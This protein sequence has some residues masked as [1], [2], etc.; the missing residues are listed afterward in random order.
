MKCEKREANG[1]ITIYL[2]LTMLIMMSLLLTLLEGIRMKT[3]EFQAKCV[4]DIGIDSI[5]AEYHREVLSRYGL[6]LVDTSYGTSCGDTEYTKDHLLKYMNM[7]FVPEGRNNILNYRDLTALH[8]DNADILSIT[9]ATD[10]EA[11]VLRYQIIRYMKECGGLSYA[12]ALFSLKDNQ[13]L[14]VEKARQD[15]QQY[16]A[17]LNQ[18]MKEL[19]TNP[20]TGVNPYEGLLTAMMNHSVLDYA[21]KDPSVLSPKSIDSDLY[22]SHRD[23]QEGDGLWEEQES[24]S[25]MINQELCAS[26]Y[27]DMCGNYMDIKEDTTLDYEV[28]YLLQGKDTDKKNLEKVADDIF[29]MRYAVNAAYLFTN[30]PKCAEAEAAAAV[31]AAILLNPELTEPIKAVILAAW[32]YAESLQDLRMV[33]DQKKVPYVKTDSNWNIAFHELLTFAYHLDEYQETEEGM[34][35]KD[36]LHTFLLTKNRHTVQKRFCDIVEMNV[37]RTEG[38]SNFK[39]DN[40]AY[41]M[42]VNVN[43]SS[44]YGYGFSI[45]NKYSYE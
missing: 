29:Q 16:D 4:V 23:L 35:Y 6:L 44:E 21:I 25:G 14:H 5:F 33:Y 38:N 26:Y 9:Y 27:M 41:Q 40:C 3:M 17:E 42:E 22:T 1:S 15:Y 32:C 24:V 10:E 39:M 31:I 43:I 20:D 11:D 34:E 2:T 7:N 37:K 8:A 12:D 36:F 19:N 13:E 30:G 28:E 45:T 18:K